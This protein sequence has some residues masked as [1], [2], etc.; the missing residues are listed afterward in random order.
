MTFLKYVPSKYQKA[1]LDKK[2]YVA[3]GQSTGEHSPSQPN[4]V[5]DAV[6]KYT[7]YSGSQNLAAIL[8]DPRKTRW[9]VAAF[10][11][12]HWGESFIEKVEIPSIAHLPKITQKHFED[13]ITIIK[14]VTNKDLK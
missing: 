2:N 12:R 7:V 9:E 1:P 8:N 11:T 3:G 14:R 13:Y 10:F 6:Q 5:K 4:L